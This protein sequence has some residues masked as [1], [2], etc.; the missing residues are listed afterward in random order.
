[1]WLLTHFGDPKPWTKV[2]VQVF[3]A[4]VRVELKNPHIHAY[5]PV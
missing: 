3:L 2:E 1:M 5:N 4:R